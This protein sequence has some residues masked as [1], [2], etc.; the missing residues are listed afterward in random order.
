M[1]TVYVNILIVI[2]YFYIDYFL[3]ALHY[4]FNNILDINSHAWLLFIILDY[5]NT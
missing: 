2:N 4:S 5:Y 3:Y 1:R